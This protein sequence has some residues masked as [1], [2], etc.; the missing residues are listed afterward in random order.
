MKKKKIINL[1]QANKISQKYKRTNKICLAHGVFDVLHIGHVNHFHEIKKNFPKSLLFVSITADDYVRK[2][3]NRPYFN[4]KL[5]M[6]M[7][8]SL[9]YVDYVLCIDDYSGLPA[10]N[11]IRPH[12]YFKG[13]DYKNNT[14]FTKKISLEKKAVEKFKGQLKNTDGISF[15]SSN[16]INNYFSTNDE[17]T[18]NFLK[19]LKKK[20]TFNSIYKNIEKFKKPKILL[21]GE[22][23]I[24][25]YIYVKPLNKTPKENLISNLVIDD[26]KFLG[27]VLAAANHIAS[28]T[29]NLDLLTITGN[30][31]ETEILIKKNLKKNIKKNIFKLDNYKS[32]NKI[33]F[34]DNSYS[35]RKLF[36]L[37]EMSEN[38]IS[39]EKDKK[40]LNFLKKNIKKYDLVI[41]NDFG[42]GLFSKQII[43]FLEKKSKK[44]HI[45]VQTNSGNIPYN[46]VTK[47]KKAD[48]VTIDHTEASLAVGSNSIDI[49]SM[50]EKLKRLRKF[51]KIIITKGKGGAVY[52]KSGKKF[53]APIF[54]NE[55]VD[56]IGTGDAFFSLASLST[57]T[58]DDQALAA[59]LGNV[60][61]GI[62]VSIIGHSKNIEKDIYLKNVETLLK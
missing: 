3:P 58:N 28:F 19:S 33:R 49:Q 51:S 54:N 20:F 24:D 52:S 50:K 17:S 27:G 15:S 36:E 34:V 10:I 26:N 25:K 46:L 40:I 7:L 1:D 53:I 47:F 16:I 22:T 14:D 39:E 6:Q 44:L 29:N 55:V 12:Y 18:K 9:E 32:V 31:K 5:R 11:S 41:V 4:Q 2:S 43:D 23:I 48:F 61:G 13:A 37:Y 56:T 60:A 30:D 42:H 35:T 21:I 59:F 62:K 57:Y 8:S 38:F 45:N